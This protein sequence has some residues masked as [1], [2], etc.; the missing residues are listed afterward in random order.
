MLIAFVHNL[1]RSDA[2]EQ[3]GFATPQAVEAIASALARLGH[4][5]ERV[6]ASGPISQ[7]AARLE[8]L[9]PDLVF[10][11]AVGEQGRFREAFF[12][13]LFD[14]LGLPWTGSDAEVCAVTLDKA[15]TRQFVA[16]AGV[17]VPGGGLVRRVRDLAELAELPW[18]RIVKPN[19]EGG[20][21]GIDAGSVVADE[22]AQRRRV[23]EQLALFPD[24]L[25]VEEYIEGIDVT[26]PFLEVASEETGGVL[27]PASYRYDRDGAGDHAYDFEL[28]ARRP[29]SV[30]LQVPAELPLSLRRRVMEMAS[31][32]VRALGLRDLGRLDFR[33]DRVG[34]LWFIEADALPGLEPGASLYA[35]AALAGLETI[36]D[37]L[38]AV[39]TSAAERQEL[40]LPR[41]RQRRLRVGVT[42]D[43]GERDAAGTIA[44][45]CGT[46]TD[47][48]YDVVRLETTPELPCRL[49]ASK[50]DLGFNLAGGR[51]GRLGGALVP[52]LLE[53]AGVEYAGADPACMVLCRDR[54]LARRV[55]AAEGVPIQPF[56]I[57]RTGDDALP[58]DLDFPL[59]VRPVAG[60]GVSEP[61]VVEDQDELS[62]AITHLAARH[63]QAVLVEERLLGR[64]F[65]VFI[66]APNR[67]LLPIV[68]LLP[69]PG[70]SE[71][72]RRV[73]P[74]LSRSERRAVEEVAVRAWA[75]LGC[76]DVARIDLCQ[77]Q[78]GRIAFV[79]C[80]PLPDLAPGRSDLVLCAEAAGLDHRAL[81]ARI[82]APALG[83]LRER[84][85]RTLQVP[86]PAPRRP[87]GPAAGAD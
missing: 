39:I 33:V 9:R 82:L 75:A 18:P 84:R 54:A 2:I 61:R 19:C 3:A 64:T 1:Q 49:T 24:G 87:A 37:V 53:L 29:D 59:V 57:A 17:P 8:A 50:P 63:R 23:V 26:V 11:T 31:Q 36:E 16:A 79:G 74:E 34:S 38:A 4:D 32:A 22:E 80:E 6:E 44:A 27:E 56:W 51:E 43:P 45:V 7:L 58:D 25:L 30:S 67:T 73:R 65:S 42:F 10:N 70:E 60:P 47:L 78:D 21:R 14:K 40:A 12:P 35:S 28:V 15:M 46:L 76:R 5:V 55:A 83:R 48:G 77:G 72:Q 86:R 62:A 81:V 41:R 52:A 85:R 71:R 66:L 20:G 13:A 68:E 69:R